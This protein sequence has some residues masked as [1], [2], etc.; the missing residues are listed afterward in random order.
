[1]VAWIL[2]S[3]TVRDLVVGPNIRSVDRGTHTLKGV[4]GDWRL[5][6]SRIG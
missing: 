5:S 1:M 3:R 2:I 6:P 4:E